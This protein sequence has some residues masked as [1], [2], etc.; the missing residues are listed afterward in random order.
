MYR[1]GCS[2][3]PARVTP[4]AARRPRLGASSLSRDCST[5][6][7]APPRFW[8]MCCAGGRRNDRLRLVLGHVHAPPLELHLERVTVD[9]E[10]PGRFAPV[11]LDALEDAEHDLSFELIRRRLQRQVLRLLH[12][13]AQVRQHQ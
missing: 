10:D 13:P 3:T 7:W 9:A 1:C 11:P 4:G 12:P 6:F 8:S 5:T 2:V